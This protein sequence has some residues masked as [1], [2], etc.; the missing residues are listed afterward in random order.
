M[1]RPP[2]SGPFLPRRKAAKPSSVLMESVER[3]LMLAAD[4]VISEF[5]ASNSRT[6]ADRDGDFSDWIEIHN[7]GDAPADL[8][9][10]YLT[11]DAAD[12][13]QWPFPSVTLAPNW[14]CRVSPR[15]ARRCATRTRRPPPRA[16]QRCPRPV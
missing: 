3:R 13:D 4:V 9:G 2:R 16:A 11:D 15:F 8:T 5:M 14:P 6:L 10:W 1:H 7:R 12:P